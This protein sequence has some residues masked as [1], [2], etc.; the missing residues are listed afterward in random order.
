VYVWGDYNTNATDTTWNT[1]A[2]DE[3]GHAAASIIAD[4]VSFVSNNWNDFGSVGIGTSSNQVTDFNNRVAA[5]SYYRVAVAG[6]KNINFPQPT[7]WAAAND[8]GTDGGVHNFL[9]YLENWGGQGFNYKGSLVSLYY[10]TYGTGIYKCCTTV[11]SPPTR[12][13][14]FDLDFENPGG[15]HRE[16]RCSAM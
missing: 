4:A 12:N 7:G 10:S 11:Y 6:G 14:V 8:Y 16:R 2:V 1:P 5:T 3:A 15:C 13:D 9:R